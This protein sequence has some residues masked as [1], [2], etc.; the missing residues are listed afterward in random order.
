MLKEDYESKLEPEANRLIGNIV[1]YTRKMG[2]L[3]D[4]LLAFSRLGRKELVPGNV[5]MQSIVNNIC[6]EIGNDH[7][8]NKIEFRIKELLPAK[9][10]NVTLKQTWINLISNAV[11]YSGLK[12]NPIIEIGCVK[13]EEEIQ[14]YIKDN[15]AGFDMRYS[16]KLFGVFQRLHNEDQ[17]EG[18]GVGLAI[19]HRIISKHG[20]RVWGEGI[21][22]EGATFHFTL[23]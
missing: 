7:S 8:G 21:V 13:K 4:E 6:M 12:K 2:Q 11:K 3:I 9:G 15:G 17:F 5:S 23:P 16:D 1:N 18:T 20:G 22:D 19:V 10:D 14:Y